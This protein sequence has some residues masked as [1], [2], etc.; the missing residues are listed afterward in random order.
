MLRPQ[1]SEIVRDV[2][3]GSGEERVT[4]APSGKRGRAFE[5]DRQ[6]GERRSPKDSG[7]WSGER[8]QINGL[9]VKVTVLLTPPQEAVPV[10]E[11]ETRPSKEGMGNGARTVAPVAST[12]EEGG[13]RLGRVE[14]QA[15]I[16]SPACAGPSSATMAEVDGRPPVMEGGDTVKEGRAGVVEMPAFW[17]FES[18][19][20]RSPALYGKWSGR[21]KES[22]ARD[23]ID[24]PPLI[25]LKKHSASTSKFTRHSHARTFYRS[26]W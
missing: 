21:Y 2:G 13:I 6:T 24:P 9:K 16:A 8:S 20:G 17:L 12:T 14:V 19:S 26:P 23:P 3:H 7:G 11:V 15:T 25:P 5:S 18:G 10:P 1:L 4:T 22:G